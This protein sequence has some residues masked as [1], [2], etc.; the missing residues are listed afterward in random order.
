MTTAIPID[1]A[2]RSRKTTY[3]TDHLVDLDLF[4]VFLF[5]KQNIEKT[6]QHILLATSQSYDLRGIE[7][8]S[9]RQFLRLDINLCNSP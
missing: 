4:L 9:P 1:G 8:N 7:P 6:T 5:S 2:K 3:E